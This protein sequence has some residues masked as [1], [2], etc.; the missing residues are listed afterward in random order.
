MLPESGECKGIEMRCRR[1]LMNYILFFLPSH[2]DQ[3]ADTL[4]CVSLL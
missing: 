4:Y 1:L 2:G 3:V